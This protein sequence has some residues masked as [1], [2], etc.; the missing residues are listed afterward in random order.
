MKLSR[1]EFER[2]AALV[3][4]PPPADQQTPRMQVETSGCKQRFAGI[5]AVAA[6][7]PSRDLGGGHL[8]HIGK[9]LFDSLSGELC[10]SLQYGFG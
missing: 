9:I 2:F 6:I 4:S 10:I 8:P 7:T 1:A 5:P 3:A